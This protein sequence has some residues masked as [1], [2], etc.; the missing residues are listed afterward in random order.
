MARA[1]L[2]GKLRSLARIFLTVAGTTLAVNAL[3]FAQEALVARAYGKSPLL[4]GY[5]LG[6]SLVTFL[7][8][9]IANGFGSAVVPAY[10]R[11]Q[12]VGG[13]AA[14]A[15]TLAVASRLALLFVGAVLLVLAPMMPLLVPLLAPRFDDARRATTVFAFLLLSPIVLLSAF[16]QAWAAL[17]NARGKFALSGGAGAVRP[18][19]V[20]LV[21]LALGK[22]S[23]L[24]LAAA[25]T[26]GHA[27]TAAVLA[28]GLR[29][30]GVSVRPRRGPIDDILRGAGRQYGAIMIGSLLTST[31]LVTDQAVASYF[32]PGTIATM[33]YAQK[34]AALPAGLTLTVI[35]AVLF[36]RFALLSA[37]RDYAGLQRVR[38]QSLVASLV[39]GTLIAIVVAALSEPLTRL[40]FQRGAFHADDAVAVARLLRV[41]C[42]QFPFILVGGVLTRFLVALQYYDRVWIGLVVSPVLNLVLDLVLGRRFGIDGVIW[43]TTAVAVYSATY[44]FVAAVVLLRRDARR[45]REEREETEVFAS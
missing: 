14:A 21:L 16:A 12:E 38:T 19:L 36:P 25:V 30:V 32:P 17:L 18:I 2:F 28:D 4:D 22:P 40:A 8:G 7:V 13:S 26:V 29:R 24:V 10:L 44:F 39:L 5:V 35:A 20:V 3:S 41:S 15:S 1:G 6:L 45:A 27:G 42:V 34:L 9:V 33:N 43:S 31:M 37:Q 11:A 23:L